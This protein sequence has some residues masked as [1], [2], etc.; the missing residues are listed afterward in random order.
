MGF[1][2]KLFSSNKINVD[3]PNSQRVLHV[4]ENNNVINEEYIVEKTIQQKILDYLYNNINLLQRIVYPAFVYYKDFV[5]E[6]KIIS[7]IE[8][9]WKQS[10]KLD[11]IKSCVYNL[12]QPKLKAVDRKAR[13][14]ASFGPDN[15]NKSYIIP[16]SYYYDASKHLSSID[17]TSFIFSLS[18]G[19]HK[20]I[21]EDIMSYV[22]NP[23]IGKSVKELYL[24]YIQ[25]AFIKLFTYSKK[26]D[27]LNT[28]SDTHKIIKNAI[29]KFPDIITAADKTYTFFLEAEKLDGL[30][31]SLNDYYEF[32]LL[33]YY[34]YNENDS[35]YS[36]DEIDFNIEKMSNDKIIDFVV[37]NRYYK[38]HEISKLVQTLIY[39]QI[40]YCNKLIDAFDKISKIQYIS[41]EIK[42]KVL[43]EDLL[44]NYSQ[45]NTTIDDIDL[46]N[47]VEFEIFIKNYFEKQGY[48]CS[49][50]KTSGD[51]GI[52]V[53]AIKNK[54]KLGIQA[55]CYSGTVGNH[56]VMEA[57]AG[58]KY[59]D[60]T[61]CM[62]IT[63]NY[64]TKSAKELAT[65][66]NVVLWDRNTLQEKLLNDTE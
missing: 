32:V 12:K 4:D 11:K 5:G 51:Q 43:K 6:S 30:D 25:I 20:R 61:K 33:F 15:S 31:F 28:E 18:S 8:E 59:Y 19:S 3:I 55:K 29:F 46:M 37:S 47:G 56:A 42:S 41:D 52:D 64:F 17:L 13:F 54:V 10:L 2:K 7:F 1:L 34:R 22:D 65:K 63:N 44:N 39:E 24:T 21:E 58:A 48:K 60:C 45:A 23:K 62:V 50:T 26:L 49:I 38:T 53:I 40:K 14:I 36:S 16:T 57:V 35:F 27:T 66:N 9:A